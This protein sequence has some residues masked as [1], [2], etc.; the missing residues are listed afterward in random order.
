MSVNKSLFAVAA[1]LAACAA[2]GGIVVYPEYDAR[3]ERDYAYGV[4]V[5]QADASRRLTVYN[6][7]EK[8]ALET[9]TRGGDVN[10]RFCE[11]AFDGGPV[12][13]DV[14]VCE[15]VKSLAVFPSRLGL[16]SAF[17]D[18]VISVW[19]E[20]PCNFGIRLND[21][22]KSILSVFADAPQAAG[23]IPK[24]DDPGVMYVEGWTDPPGED[25]VTVVESPVKEVYIAPGAVLNSRLVVKAAGACIHGRGMILDPMSDIFRFDQSKNT[26][27]GVVGISA[28]G[29][30]VEDVKIVDARTFNY[31]VWG[32]DVTLRNVKALSTMMC[33]DGITCGG[34]GFRVEGA[35]LY[36]GDN[37]LVVSGVKGGAL[38]RD[39]AIGTS[40]NAI[41]PQN[42]NEG[43]VMENIDVF[44]ADEGCIKNTY[45]GVLCRNTKW[46]EL[47]A[48]AARREP[49]PQDLVHRSQEFFFKN[50]SAVDCVL[51]PRFFLCGNM[52]TLPKRF[53]FDGVG[54]PRPSGSAGW[55]EAGRG[56]GP[57]VEVLHDSSKWL[58][59]A[60]WSLAVTNL[61][62]G[63]E[64]VDEIPADKV[65]NG[66]RI[67]I[68][69][70]SSGERQG[71]SA[72]A[73]RKCVGGI[74]P[75]KVFV[76]DVLQRDIRVIAPKRGERRLPLMQ[77]GNLLADADARANARSAWQRNPSWLS[78]FDAV[79]TDGAS[80]VYRLRQC[81][82]G[83]GMMNVV[84][85]A[86]LRRGNGSYRFAFEARARCA[87][88]VAIE[89]RL[90]SN[91]TRM[92]ERFTVHADGEWHAYSCVIE[93]DFDLAAT[94]LVALHLKALAPVDELC[95]KNLS[96]AK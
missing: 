23:K 11:F 2:R 35:W 40:C 96:L 53:A 14:A 29:A 92:V 95:F 38:F 46:N 86:F 85:D 10:R 68:S 75:W 77:G 58:D 39:V 27:R 54:I 66:D 88:D 64:R 81:E 4:R 33:S 94:E 37:A 56:D 25:G 16:K 80:R 32:D 15:D 18:G 31:C 17:K 89:A 22:D 74:C 62:V 63:G 71:V 73:N 36:V 60:N 51:F 26:R 67:A 21:S 30:V 52:G 59:S 8:S 82:K 13:V 7:C 42:S 48:G 20:R 49:G 12:R 79:E 76:G 5:V 83:G 72:E 6:R 45:N 50:L 57:L 43:V 78:K 93:T 41:F 69:V 19:I 91:E 24:K 44:R 70:V 47:D 55:R 3:I 65:V 84:T 61:W 87:A 90:F 34:R 1:A 28:G 9:R